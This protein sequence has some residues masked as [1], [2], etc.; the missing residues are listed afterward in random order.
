MTGFDRMKVFKNKITKKQVA[1]VIVS[2]GMVGANMAKQHADATATAASI[3]LLMGTSN[4]DLWYLFS[5]CGLEQTRETLTPFNVTKK[6]VE[7]G[8]GVEMQVTPV[9][10][11]EQAKPDQKVE[12]VDEKKK[13]DQRIEVKFSGSGHNLVFPTSRGILELPPIAKF[14]KSQYEA[15]NHVGTYMK[16]QDLFS[17]AAL[18]LSGVFSVAKGVVVP[19]TLQAPTMQ[20]V[21]LDGILTESSVISVHGVAEE[22]TVIWKRYCPNSLEGP[23]GQSGATI[24]GTDFA[25]HMY[26]VL[27]EWF[28][29]VGIAPGVQILQ[30]WFT[31]YC[32]P[33]M[34]LRGGIFQACQPSIPTS[35]GDMKYVWKNKQAT[36]IQAYKTMLESRNYRGADDAEKSAMARMAY[37]N[38]LL[39]SEIAEVIYLA[40]DINRFLKGVR[41]IFLAGV[42]TLAPWIQAISLCAALYE[43]PIDVWC[44]YGSDVGQKLVATL[45][46]NNQLVNHWLDSKVRVVNQSDVSGS[47]SQIAIME[48]DLVIDT[49]LISAPYTTISRDSS[50]GTTMSVEHEKRVRKFVG[51]NRPCLARLPLYTGILT[52]FGTDQMKEQ[53]L[54]MTARHQGWSIVSG[55]KLH[56]MVAWEYIGPNLYTPILEN[57]QV[58]PLPHGIVSDLQV[59]PGDKPPQ[60]IPQYFDFRYGKVW[61]YSLDKLP[62]WCSATIIANVARVQYPYTRRG[63]CE[64]L[65]KLGH[66]PPT[67]GTKFLAKLSTYFAPSEVLALDEIIFKELDPDAFEVVV[68]NMPPAQQTVA[69]QHYADVR[70]VNAA[71]PAEQIGSA[72]TT[73]DDDNPYDDAEYLPA[74]VP[75]DQ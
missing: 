53:R 22:I 52:V 64:M 67:V 36:L 25:H 11:V 55:V 56:N 75:D 16:S 51:W 43:V 31:M 29:D 2:R 27:Y 10:V 32:K 20:A 38:I 59:R 54:T 73:L 21:G 40:A 6:L 48:G 45:D 49:S 13:T 68:S 69:R 57:D 44:A 66:K 39:T 19:I 47:L 14:S 8:F 35:S 23:V 3:Q 50:F 41:R 26:L 15:L 34:V 37:L 4:A 70:A 61:W 18:A 72:L 71:A 28:K 33:T 1:A 58:R 42:G 65:T 7:G 30:S 5:L 12:I 17:S 24:L 60:L 74:D 46:D 62:E 9:P 63:P